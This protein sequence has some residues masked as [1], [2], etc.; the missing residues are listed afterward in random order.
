M[1]V[2]GGTGNTMRISTFAKLQWR[3]THDVRPSDGKARI[4]FSNAYLYNVL[5]PVVA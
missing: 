3:R 1:Y 4:G 2:P 5:Q